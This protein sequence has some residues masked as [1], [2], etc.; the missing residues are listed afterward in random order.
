MGPQDSYCS[1]ITAAFAFG[2][3]KDEH[4]SGNPDRLS[5]LLPISIRALTA[6]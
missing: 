3:E 4:G 2:R 5:N 1:T 6:M